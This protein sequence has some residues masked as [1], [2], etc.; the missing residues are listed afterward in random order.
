MFCN[1]YLPL[2]SHSK[3]TQSYAM[4]KGVNINLI[5]L[6]FTSEL[7]IYK[8]KRHYHL[9]ILKIKSSYLHTHTHT[10]IEKK[11]LK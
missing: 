6:H 2:Y 9:I 7:F 5:T 1:I 4:M 11:K 3:L 8:T 10:H